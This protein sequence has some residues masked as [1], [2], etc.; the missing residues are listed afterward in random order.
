[1]IISILM[2][3]GKGTRL[4]ASCEKPLFKFNNKPLISYTLDNLLNSDVDV[5][6]IALS[7]HTKKTKEFLIE[8]GSGEFEN[9]D[10][11]VSYI[12]TPGEGYINDYNYLLGLLEVFSKDNVVFSINADLPLISSDIINDFLYEYSVQDKDA[13]SVFVPEDVVIGWNIDYAY[14]FRGLVPTGVNIVRSENIIQEQ[15]DLVVCDKPQLALNI[16]TKHN[17]QIA[18]NFLKENEYLEK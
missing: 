18:L 9:L 8:K 16:N 17:L 11:K 15:T 2:A 10:Q 1:M 6:I 12:V 7:P 3:G 13:L 14:V 4:K 5:V